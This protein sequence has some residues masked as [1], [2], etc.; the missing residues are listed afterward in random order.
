MVRRAKGEGAWGV[1]HSVLAL[2]AGGG[3]ELAWERNYEDPAA[4]DLLHS[5]SPLMGPWTILKPSK[6][7]S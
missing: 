1:C 6:V 4:T 3:N 7:S 2:V 5:D